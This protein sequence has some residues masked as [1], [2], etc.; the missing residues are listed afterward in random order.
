[1]MNNELAFWGGQPYGKSDFLSIIGPIRKKAFTT[2]IIRESFKER[3]IWPVDGSKIVEDLTNRLEIPDLIAPDLRS[4]GAHTPSPPPPP[5]NLTSS[6]VDISPP[7]SIQALEKNQAKIRKKIDALPAKAQRDLTKVFMHQ[8][9]LY[10]R[11]AMTEDTIRRIRAA[12][13]PQ[14]KP[15]SQ[16]GILTTRD[17]IRSI[18]TR[19][20]EEAAKEERKLAKQFKKV[21]GYEPTERSEESIQRAIANE[22]A[23]RQA[24]EPFFVDN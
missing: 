9:E 13:M 22:I 1:M 5:L 16:T 2:R 19:K 18:T 7:K 4:W 14:V 21:Y 24:G 10:E 8:R 11:L 12:Q 3:G 17:A 6:D 23:A 15:L 20:E